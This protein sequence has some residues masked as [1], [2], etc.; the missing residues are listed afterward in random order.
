MGAK[1]TISSA[2]LPVWPSVV[3]ITERLKYHVEVAE[4]IDSYLLSSEGEIAVHI[5]YDGVRHLSLRAIEE[6]DERADAQALCGYL[7]FSHYTYTSLHKTGAD[8]LPAR[9]KLPLYVP[10]EHFKQHIFNGDELVLTVSYLQEPPERSLFVNATLVDDAQIR[11]WD[12]IPDSFLEGLRLRLHIGADVGNL[13]SQARE[14]I[15]EEVEEQ[16]KRIQQVYQSW[17]RVVETLEEGKKL[18][19][20]LVEEML[21]LDPSRGELSLEAARRSLL[22][23]EDLLSRLTKIHQALQQLEQ[24]REGEFSAEAIYDIIAQAIGQDTNQLSQGGRR[25]IESIE[26]FALDQ[27]EGARIRYLGI[28]W[29]Y[30]EPEVGWPY[31]NQSPLQTNRMGWIYNPETGTMEQH[32]VRMRWDAQR[33]HFSVNLDLPLHRP[34]EERPTIQGHVLVKT[35][36][37]MSGLHVSW[38]DVNGVPISSIHPIV[39]TLIEVEFTIKL[40]SAF[41]RRVFLPRRQLFF[42]GVFPSPERLSEIEGVLTDAGLTILDRS[43]SS[44]LEVDWKSPLWVQAMKRSL[45]LPTQIWVVVRGSPATGRHTVIFDRGRQQVEGEVT[46]GN[47][48]IDLY[49][50][51]FGEIAA[52]SNLLDDVQLKLQHRLGEVSTTAWRV[53]SVS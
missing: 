1:K 20:S 48:R 42:G 31:P 51:T 49:G 23:A 3:R 36:K 16:R 18:P 46:Q 44:P 4:R 33:R 28:I 38:L 45:G 15:V 12:E 9:V 53:G 7:G 35:N 8:P 22:E 13:S 24:K 11:R 29:P 40:E 34:A 5:P 17:R 26:R 37:L 30:P 27:T 39:Q 19:P 41:R 32:N 50:Q 2:K 6:V 14:R 10:C 43:Y 21:K 52:L 47:L 25:V